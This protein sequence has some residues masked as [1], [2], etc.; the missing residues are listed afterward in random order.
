[1]RNLNGHFGESIDLLRNTGMNLSFLK[2]NVSDH[3]GSEVTRAQSAH[4]YHQRD[5][6][7]SSHSPLLLRSHLASSEVHREVWPSQLVCKDLQML[8]HAVFWSHVLHFLRLWRSVVK[9]FSLPMT[10]WYRGPWRKEFFMLGL[11]HTV[12]CVK[13]HT[14][15]EKR[16]ARREEEPSTF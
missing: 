13:P 1:M 5:S 3:T 14:F 11:M 2:E 4:L 16:R 6:T 7:H 9:T 8:F 10:F 12:T 15:T